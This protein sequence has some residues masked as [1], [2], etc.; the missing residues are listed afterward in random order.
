[1]K[2][3]RIIVE[4]RLDSQ[5]D[6]QQNQV[7]DFYLRSA[8][9]KSYGKSYLLSQPFSMGVWKYFKNGRAL[10]EI[11]AFRAWNKNPRLDKTIVRLPSM[12]RYIKREQEQQRCA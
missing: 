7:I 11:M 2:N 5:P 4:V 1:M 6:N 12:I 9:G 10:S 8:D 3:D